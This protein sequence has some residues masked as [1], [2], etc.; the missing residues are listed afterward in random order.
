MSKEG[1][2]QELWFLDS[3]RFFMDYDTYRFSMH[4]VSYCVVS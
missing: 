1:K 4:Y 3:G 2:G